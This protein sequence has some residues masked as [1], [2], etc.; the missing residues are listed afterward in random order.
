MYGELELRNRV[1]QENHATDCQ[2]IEELKKICCEEANGTRQARIDELSAHQE[3]NPT[4]V[5]QLLT[6][7]Q[8]LHNKLN[9]LSDAKEFYDPETGSSSGAT[10]VPGQ[11]LAILSPR[12]MPRCESGLLRDTRNFTRTSGNVFDRPP[13]QEGRSSTVFN[14]SKNLAS[15]SQ[16]LRPGI[17]KTTRRRESEMKRESLNTSIPLPHFQCGNDM[18]TCSHSGMMDYPRI[19]ITEMHLGKFPDSME[20]HGWNVTFKNEKSTRTANPPDH[21]APD[22]RS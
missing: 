16:E 7:I 1:F 3:R 19:P 8:D 21:Y 9:S 13:A 12:N 17:A 22:Q 6:L 2:E 15:S 18:L 14:N 10:R 5:S 11:T 20:F 4:T